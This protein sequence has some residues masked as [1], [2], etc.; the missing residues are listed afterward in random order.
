MGDT[1]TLEESFAQAQAK[2]GDSTLK[3]EPTKEVEPKVEEQ[4]EAQVATPEEPQAEDKT[5]L[6]RIDPEKLPPELKSVYKDLMKGFT[7]GRQKD[8]ERAKAAEERAKQLEE[9][10]AKIEQGISPDSS[11]PK[12]PQFKTVEEYY[13]YVASQKVEEKLREEKINSY[14]EQALNDYEAADERL[15]R[16]SEGKE[17]PAYDE[18]MDVSISG[19]LDELLAEHVAKNG[20]ELGFD[21][22]GETKRLIEQW[23]EWM[24]GR[25][26]SYVEKQNQLI[27]SKA[28]SSKAINP[29]T[30]SAKAEP[31]KAMSLS[32]ALQAAQ[33]KLSSK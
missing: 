23:E 8:S 18:F 14:R 28:G 6:E 30:S 26:K 31:A 13:D 24:Q 15:R 10:L 4:T 33:E 27:K 17:N 21:H 16:P 22:K 1:L 5:E 20:S 19:K 7:Q 29:K 2:V 12:A 3:E 25:I 32:E 11:S 9:R